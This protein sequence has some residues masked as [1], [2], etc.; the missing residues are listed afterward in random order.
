VTLVKVGRLGRPHGL[1]GEVALDSCD[2]TPLE[3]HAVRTFTWRGRAG[4]ERP[5]TLHTARPAHDRTLV[6][7]TGITSRAQ[8]S[9]LTLGELWVDDGVLPDPGPG[10]AYA[11][12]LIGLRVVE[13]DGRELGTIADVV[14][15]GAHPI[16]IVRG[17]RE[18]LVPVIP[19]VVRKVDLTAR[20][21]TVALP[22]GLE[23]L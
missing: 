20:V 11:Y 10:V 14:T 6:H 2:L 13:A 22:A 8:A 15:T 7:F 17:D 1:H 18:L 5:L 16:Y 9:E 12:Q 19:D 23:D 21:V 4:A 3:L